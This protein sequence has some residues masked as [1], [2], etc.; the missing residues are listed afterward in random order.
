[1]RILILLLLPLG[2][3][4]QTVVN[5]GRTFTGPVDMSGATSTKLPRSV[6]SDPG[7]CTAPDQIYNS[8][9]GIY[10]NCVSGAWVAV[11]SGA[12]SNCA[13]ADTGSTATLATPC[14]VGAG[15][16]ADVSLASD[17][18]FTPSSGTGTATFVF[19]NGGFHVYHDVAG[20]TSAS[21][22]AHSGGATPP[23]DSLL[24][25]TATITSGATASAVTSSALRFN[26]FIDGSLISFTADAAGNMIPNLSLSGYVTD[27]N[28]RLVVTG[29]DAG[30]T[31]AYAYT[32]SPAPAAYVTGAH[33][34][35]KANTANTGAATV[36]VNS[37]GAKTI[38]KMA[39][40]ITTDLADNDIRAGQ[41]VDLIY[42]G[43]NMQMTSQVG[44]AAGGG[45][46]AAYDGTDQTA[47]TCTGGATWDDVGTLTVPGVAAGSHI[48]YASQI[49]K[50]SGSGSYNVRVRV[51]GLD[52]MNDAGIGVITCNSSE[53]CAAWG[54]AMVLGGF[55]AF[56]T[57]VG[58][59]SVSVTPIARLMSLTTP[60]SLTV[61]MQ[62]NCSTAGDTFRITET[63][64]TRLP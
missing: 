42:D 58:R 26:P 9:S 55:T 16:I 51:N 49:A 29:S 10:K 27:T 62:V 22:T 21:C 36:N 13:V 39:G 53:N 61:L 8:T 33:Y 60:T 40:A 47:I 23:L 11:G 4:A 56:R 5:G 52:V 34:R 48:L 35:F 18:V 41:W 3:F 6:A 19:R 57:Q 2:A 63:T 31:D 28:N 1:M 50:A 25:G 20:T 17:C 64:Y 45:V 30:S 43:T 14:V 32:P 38:K 12:A 37:L 54:D 44:N 7:S 15:V 24:L 46:T 59:P